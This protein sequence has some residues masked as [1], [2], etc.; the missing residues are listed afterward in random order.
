MDRYRTSGLAANWLSGISLFNV[1]PHSRAGHHQP[2]PPKTL[3]EYPLIPKT[4]SL[5]SARSGTKVAVMANEL[6]A[7]EFIDDD[8]QTARKSPSSV[9]GNPF[10][11]VPSDAQRAPTR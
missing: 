7:S 10:A 8:F 1:R 6:D 4:L 5:H 9:T 2:S 3:L 11:T